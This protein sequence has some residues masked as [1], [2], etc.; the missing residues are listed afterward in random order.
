MADGN[1][2]ESVMFDIVEELIEAILNV[3]RS[4]SYPLAGDVEAF[5]EEAGYMIVPIEDPTN[6]RFGI[7]E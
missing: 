6:L 7:D 4:H 3:Y 2:E 1:A 5:L